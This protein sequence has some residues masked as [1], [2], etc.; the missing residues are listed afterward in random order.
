MTYPVVIRDF[1]L[2]YPLKN[3]FIIVQRPPSYHFSTDNKL[4]AANMPDT[5][6]KLRRSDVKQLR[7]YAGKQLVIICILRIVWLRIQRCHVS[8]QRG[9]VAQCR[10]TNLPPEQP[11]TVPCG[12]DQLSETGIFCWLYLY[13][14]A[15]MI[16]E[17]PVNNPSL[18][19]ND[20]L[21][22]VH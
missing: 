2:R 11:Q 14:V 9:A 19:G 21:L 15:V 4:S 10:L 20:D 5:R 22:N 7:I 6:R 1:C 3:P 8:G 17:A 13:A 16:M 18:Q 12:D